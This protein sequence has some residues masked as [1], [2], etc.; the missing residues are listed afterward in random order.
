LA[1][2]EDDVIDRTIGELR[3]DRQAGL[4]APDDRRGDA[5]QRQLTST[6][7]LVGLVTMS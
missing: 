6:V 3:A 4:T 2:L 5:S 1:A 7:T